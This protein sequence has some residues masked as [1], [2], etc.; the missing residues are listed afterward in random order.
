MMTYSS[1][2]M[3]DAFTLSLVDGLGHVRYQSSG[4][5][6][7]L[8]YRPEQV[9]GSDWFSFLH[10][11]DA[12]AVREQFRALVAAGAASGRW[13]VR[14]IAAGGRSLPLEVRARNLLADP[15]VGGILLSL[16]QMP[17]N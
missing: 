17:M 10:A 5:Q 7:L 11:D 4:W 15:D 13:I 12:A 1:G 2:R 8:G 3:H 6:T 16:R 9:E 14:F